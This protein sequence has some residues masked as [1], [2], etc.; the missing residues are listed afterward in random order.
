M[1]QRLKNSMTIRRHVLS[2]SEL[3]SKYL[4]FVNYF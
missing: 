3:K 4:E 2:P 1:F